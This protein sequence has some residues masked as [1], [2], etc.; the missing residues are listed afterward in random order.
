MFPG[1]T[2]DLGTLALS[3]R[4]LKALYFPGTSLHLGTL[5]LSS[6]S[7]KVLY[8]LGQFSPFWCGMQHAKKNAQ[9]TP[10][11]RQETVLQEIAAQTVLEHNS[12]DS[13]MQTPMSDNF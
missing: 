4:S 10:L 7:L 3:S 1:E 9:N 13:M 5:A 8:F 11:L 6:R 2:S 12:C